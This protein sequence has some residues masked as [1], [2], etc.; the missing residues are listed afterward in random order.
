MRGGY[1]Q[2]R[3]LRPS[4]GCYH[5]RIRFMD[6]SAH[7]VCSRL[8]GPVR[9]LGRC[10]RS[11]PAP[12]S[13]ARRAGGRMRRNLSQGR[14]WE[15]DAGS[16]GRAGAGG[17]CAPFA[18]IGRS[19]R[20]RAEGAGGARSGWGGRWSWAYRQ[21]HDGGARR[22]R[23]GWDSAPRASRTAPE[24]D[25]LSESP[26][27]AHDR[28]ERSSPVNRKKIWLRSVAGAQCWR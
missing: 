28:S 25:R 24:P 15:C 3:P 7:S 20:K 16:A 18:E 26:A 8:R 5:C 1:V 9:G 11:R 21:W 12:D 13:L 17:P 22:L 10:S 4:S 14:W 6:A 23:R 2:Y 27:A 19:R